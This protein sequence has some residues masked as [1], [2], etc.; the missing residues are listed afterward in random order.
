MS[1]SNYVKKLKLIKKLLFILGVKETPA[2]KMIKIN[3]S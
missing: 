2:G 1:L 3:I